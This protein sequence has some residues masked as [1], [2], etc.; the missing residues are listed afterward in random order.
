MSIAPLS[1]QVQGWNPS[2]GAPSLAPYSMPSISSAPGLD[3]AMNNAIQP[4]GGYVPFQNNTPAGSGDAP[5]APA[6]NPMAG[7]SP[8]LSGLGSAAGF[9]MGGPVG[10]IGGAALGTA[11]DYLLG[12]YQR[13]AQERE[14]RKEI[15][16]R[17]R[18]NKRLEAKADANM[19][20][21][22]M[23]QAGQDERSIEQLA[24]QNALTKKNQQM[25]EQDRL[26]QAI[27][28]ARQNR[29]AQQD[30]LIQRGF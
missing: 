4:V 8:G 3:T 21:D 9:V 27:L 2:V 5:S 16:R 30:R 14:L 18:E 1:M 29:Q 12:S 17:E 24:F 25:S 22:R 19:A 23:R 15:A 6:T 13:R 7:M 10:A 20:Y 26:R 11:A 28:T